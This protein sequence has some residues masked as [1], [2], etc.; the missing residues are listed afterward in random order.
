M[1]YTFWSWKNGRQPSINMQYCGICV[2]G[3]L[4][5]QMIKICMSIHF[6]SPK[7]AKNACLCCSLDPTSRCPTRTS[8]S[9]SV[10]WVIFWP[11]R[12]GLQCSV[13]VCSSI[14]DCGLFPSCF[15]LCF[16]TQLPLASTHQMPIFLRSFHTLIWT[17]PLLNQQT[18]LF[19]DLHYACSSRFQPIWQS[20]PSWAIVHDFS[21]KFSQI[22][23]FV[24]SSG[25]FRSCSLRFFL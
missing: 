1:A 7:I 11:H 14:F 17:W 24:Q 9:C 3:V 15:M 21:S 23:Y 8:D 13:H 25:L 16:S 6:W 2:Q 10:V 20:R 22:T 12:S 5:S 18:F 19:H 4:K